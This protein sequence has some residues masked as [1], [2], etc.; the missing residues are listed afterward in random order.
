MWAVASEMSSKH[1]GKGVKTVN[2]V[3][4]EGSEPFEGRAFEDGGKGF[5]ED[6]IMGCI[7]DDIM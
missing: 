3:W 2:R 1:V 5:V 7:E 6:D 4:R